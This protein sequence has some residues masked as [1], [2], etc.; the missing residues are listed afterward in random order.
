VPGTGQQSKP[1]AQEL[2][3]LG[4]LAFDVRLAKGDRTRRYHIRPGHLP[5]EWHAQVWLGA[6]L[7]HRGERTDITGA[8]YVLAQYKREIAELGRRWLESGGVIRL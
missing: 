3:A 4:Y 8:A 5:G 7:Q 6:T 1:R 2:A